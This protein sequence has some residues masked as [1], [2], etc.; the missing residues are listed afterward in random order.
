MTRSFD[1]Q[2]V[3]QHHIGGLILVL[4]LG[5][6]TVCFLRRRRPHR[7][8]TD[9]DVRRLRVNISGEGSGIGKGTAR[10]HDHLRGISVRILSSAVAHIIELLIEDRA[11]TLDYR[12]GCISSHCH[13]TAGQELIVVHDVILAVI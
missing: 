2:L 6:V 9:P 4:S 5:I 3:I 13:F 12:Q 8:F 10:L 1:R 7:T 11:H